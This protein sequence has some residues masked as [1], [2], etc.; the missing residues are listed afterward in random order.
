MT[1]DLYGTAAPAKQPVTTL[2]SLAA[3]EWI[4]PTTSG[5]WHLMW[6]DHT[7]YP[8]PPSGGFFHCDLYDSGDGWHFEYCHSE[9]AGG[10]E[11][12]ISSHR[13]ELSPEQ[14][15]AECK[16]VLVTHMKRWEQGMEEYA[17]RLREQEQG[18]DE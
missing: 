5:K 11:F 14:A 7:D 18:D 2:E 8:D 6:D 4:G 1:F 17:A 9:R 12:Y 16:C 15:M 10:G 13:S 3:A